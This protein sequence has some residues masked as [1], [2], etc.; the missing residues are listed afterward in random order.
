[1]APACCAA[2]A[3]ARRALSEPSTATSQG[4]VSGR[5]RQRWRTVEGEADEAAVGVA[6]GSAWGREDRSQLAHA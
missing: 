3:T 5:R 6:L 4:F 1:M 2:W